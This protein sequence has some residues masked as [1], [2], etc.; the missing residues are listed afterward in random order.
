VSERLQKTVRERYA[1]LA[2]AARRGEMKSCCSAAGFGC[3][4]NYTPEEAL[5]LPPELLQASLGCGNPVAAVLGLLEEAGLTTA[6]VPDDMANFFVARSP[7]VVGTVGLE[8]FGAYALLRSLA[9]APAYRG[10][11]LGRRLVTRA[12]EAAM[13]RGVEGIFLLTV[14][15]Q[16]FFARLG[17]RVIGREEVPRRCGVP[18]NSAPF[19]RPPQ[20]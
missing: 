18:W 12:V 19:A 10:R 3:G 1:A 8:Y 9:V 6:G 14:T 13:E 17:F 4:G 2:E 5:G 16:D 11:G 7:E 15:A 20:R